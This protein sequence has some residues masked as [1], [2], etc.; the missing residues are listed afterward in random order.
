MIDHGA[1]G[2]FYIDELSGQRVTPTELNQWLTTLEDAVPNIKVNV[3]IEA[4]QSGSFLGRTSGISKDNRVIITSTTAEHDAKASKEGAYFSDHLLTWLHQGYNLSVAFEEART[5]ATKVFSLQKPQIDS[6]GNGVP[7][8]F[9]DGAL[10]AKRSFAYANTLSSDDWPPHI[11]SVTAP[12]VIEGFQGRIEAD[13]RDNL[14][15]RQVLAVV[16]PPDYVP[17]VTGQVLQAEELPTFLLSPTGEDNRYA[18]VITGL[19]QPGAYR[20]LIHAEDNQGL[21]AHP[22]EIEIEIGSTQSQIFLP[23]IT[24]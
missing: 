23:L 19:I 18:G 6:N 16:Y 12:A 10:A 17:P 14:K 20:I 3:I 13:I 1:P 24:R 22:K 21:Q 15:V 11:F 7:N 9:S 2:L 5:V 4:C 8:E